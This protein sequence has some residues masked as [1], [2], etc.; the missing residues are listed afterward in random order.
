MRFQKSGLKDPN[1][2]VYADT[3]WPVHLQTKQF[4]L[5]TDVS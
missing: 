5:N 1:V 4:S 3:I 2:M